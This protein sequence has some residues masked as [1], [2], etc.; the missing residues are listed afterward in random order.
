MADRCHGVLPYPPF[1]KPVANARN[2]Q[3]QRRVGDGS[4]QDVGF[5]SQARRMAVNGLTPG[6]VYQFRVRAL[7]GSTGTSDWSP[8]VS[9]MSL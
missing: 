8:T 2:Y 1:E 5:Y 6:T 3:V 7:G 9:Q 4:W